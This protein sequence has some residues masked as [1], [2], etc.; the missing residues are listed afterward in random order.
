MQNPRRS[1]RRGCALVSLFYKQSAVVMNSCRLQTRLAI[2]INGNGIPLFLASLEID[3]I[4]IRCVKRIRGNLR[5]AVCYRH[6]FQ[7]TALIKCRIQFGHTACNGCGLQAG[8]IF[9]C[10]KT[11][12]C[13]AVR[14]GNARQTCAC[15]K[16]LRANRLHTVRDVDGFQIFAVSKGLRPDFF[17]TAR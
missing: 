8:T 4:Q 1:S 13:H 7:R 10:L 14:N 15:I 2:V 12:R 11:K 5:H 17:Y 9:K 16:C 3:I 6:C